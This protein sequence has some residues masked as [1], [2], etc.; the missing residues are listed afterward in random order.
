MK[1][2]EHNIEYFFNDILS[3]FQN[4]EYYDTVHEQM[5]VSLLENLKE[6]KFN[7]KILDEVFY[8]DD[9]EKQ[10][11]LIQYIKKHFIEEEFYEIIN[12]IEKVYQLWKNNDSKE[13]QELL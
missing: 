2:F 6:D 4:G 9:K 5:I 3:Q 12:D 11:Q 7:F 10:L 1:K 8:I 13:L